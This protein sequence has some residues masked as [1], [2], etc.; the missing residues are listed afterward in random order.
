MQCRIERMHL[1]EFKHAM[2]WKGK[3]MQKDELSYM[4]MQEWIATTYLM[5]RA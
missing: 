3:L 2:M 5:A 4:P 1:R